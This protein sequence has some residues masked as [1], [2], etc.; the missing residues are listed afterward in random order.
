MDGD[1]FIGA[2]LASV[3]TKL[4]I[5]YNLAVKDE[6]KQNRFTAEAMLVLSSILHLV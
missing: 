1:F 3:L 4:A 2:S 5:R 6:K